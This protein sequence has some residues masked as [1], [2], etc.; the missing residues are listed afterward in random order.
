MEYTKTTYRATTKN[1]TNM[2]TIDYIAIISG[3]ITIISVSINI[4]QYLHRLNERRTLVSQA[5]ANYNAY[6]QIAR[7]TTRARNYKSQ[8]R[9]ERLLDEIY[10]ISGVA[11]SNRSSIISFSREILNYKVFYEHPAFPGIEQSD[12][13]KL[14]HTPENTLEKRNKENTV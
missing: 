2:K 6:Y 13:I 8:D 7:S 12:E 9:V 5:Q 4:I 1:Y 14:G 10:F 11:D 3:V